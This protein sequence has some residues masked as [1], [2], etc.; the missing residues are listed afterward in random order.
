MRVGDFPLMDR[1]GFAKTESKYSASD[2]TYYLDV[3]TR[4]ALGII[5]AITSLELFV[6]SF[7]IGIG[8]GFYHHH[9]SDHH[10]HHHRIGCGQGFM[11]WMAEMHFPNELSL[12]ANLG[13]TICHIDHHPVVFV[14]YCAVA[15]GMWIGQLIDDPIS[16]SVKW[17]KR[18]V[19][20]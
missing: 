3:I 14:P 11:E 17:I 20:G 16:N 19:S 5:A 7:V 8:V 9:N 15:L 12:L 6:P 2:L 18:Q 13:V 4:I 10:H 1:L